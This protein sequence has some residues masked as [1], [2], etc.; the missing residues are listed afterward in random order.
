MMT[1]VK[2]QVITTVPAGAKLRLSDRQA[3]V[4]AN[5]R[6]AI[7]KGQYL[8]LEPV[9]FKAGEALGLDLK[10][11]PKALRDGLIVVADAG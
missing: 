8:V 10:S 3:A 4:R 7:S 1:S 9:Q 2:T 11:L 5:R 6:K